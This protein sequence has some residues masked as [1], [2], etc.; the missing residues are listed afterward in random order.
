MKAVISQTIFT[1]M[2]TTHGASRERLRA[3]YDTNGWP[4]TPRNEALRADP[5]GRSPS[6]SPAISTCRPSST[7]ASTRHRDGPVA[8]AGPAVNVGYPRWFEPDQPGRNRPPGAPENTGDFTDHFGHPM[9]VLAVANGALQPRG[10]VLDVLRQPAS[11]LGLVR[12]DKPHRTITFFCWPLLA[13]VTRPDSQFP[14]W[15]V[16]VSASDCD[17]RRPS[18]HLPR[19]EVRGAPEP[20]IHVVEESSGELLYAL[21]LPSPTFRPPIFRPGRYTVR[22][23]EPDSGRSRELTGLEPSD[24]DDLAIVV[25]L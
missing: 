17:G 13:D 16:T 12:F 5:Q 10:T 21:R 1:A 6:T 9:T 22:L 23:S 18:A 11:G 2:A 15:P 24:E 14:G 7:T 19:V 25:A 4:Q 20:V 3:D 8:F